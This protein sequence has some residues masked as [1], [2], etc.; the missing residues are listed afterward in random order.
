MA[1]FD[2]LLIPTDFSE[3][4]DKACVFAG[5]IASKS[6]AKSDLLHVIPEFIYND[7]QIRR[8]DA[9]GNKF[10][11]KLYPHL[12][13]E[14]EL[15]L[16]K[17]LYAYFPASFR[18]VSHIMV[19]RKPSRIIADHAWKGNYSLIV[20][21][22]RGK[23]Q[24]EFYRGS[25]TEE[26]IRLS[27]VPV[28]RIY[29]DPLILEN[30]RIVVPVDGSLLSMASIHAA[31]FI[32]SIFNASISL[33]YVKQTFGFLK[34]HN[35]A[36]NELA[37]EHKARRTLINQLKDFLNPEDTGN[38]TYHQADTGS[39]NSSSEQLTLDLDGNLI[40]VSVDFRA[41]LS[42]HHEITTYANRYAGL[43]VMSTHGRSGVR[44]LVMGSNA[45]KVALNAETSVLTI[46]PDS[47]LFTR[48]HKTTEQ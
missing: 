32:A 45:E 33:L 4:A 31:A 41:G 24:S 42:A 37:D 38:L 28:L 9:D 12:F 15:G 18:G 3:S 10:Q 16:K 5:K 44:Q 27:K 13:N 17:K 34:P 43:V 30:G 7:N 11:D 22:V 47:K 29:D 20:I 25:T 14:A 39:A 6:N 46:R 1:L 19:G 35:L 2:K 36:M 26:V 23:D 21:S 8:K 48:Q 40:P